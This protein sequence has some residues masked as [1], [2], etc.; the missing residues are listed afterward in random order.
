MAMHRILISDKMSP[1]GLSYFTGREGFEIIYNPEIT[2]EEL[3]AQIGDYDALVIRSRSRVTRAT[4]DRPG[5][6]KIIGRAGAGVDNVDV[7]AATERGVIVMNTPG[8]NTLSTAEHTI[9]MM[10]S[11]ARRIPFADRTMHEGKW[12]KSGIMGVEMFEKTLGI[13]GVGKIGREVATR[14]R[15]FGMDVLVYDPFLTEEAAAQM[16]VTL[17][18]V[19]TIVEKADVLTVHC[20]LN[21]ET[22]GI[23]GAAR[24]AKMKPT[25][26]VVNCARGGIIDEEALFNALKEK[27]IAGASLDVYS[28]E[29]LP[30]DH[31]FR[32]LT[33]VVL[34]P[35][36]AAST[37]E[38]Q[39]KV[40]RDI[41][42]QIFEA[43][44]DGQIRNAV[45]APS[46]D[47]KTYEKMRPVLDLAERLGKFLVQFAKP[48]VKQLDIT[49]SGTATEYS[50]KPITTALV[51]GFLERS[52]SESVNAVNALY[53]AKQ[54]GIKINEI[55]SSHTDDV[56]SGLVTVK[57]TS[58][59]GQVNEISGTLYQSRFPRLVV[60]NGKRVDATPQG[61]MLVLENK[62]VPGIIG[63]I[64]TIL[65][66]QGINIAAMNWGR[67][68]PG[69]DALTV[70]NV[71]QSVSD[72]VLQELTAQN[73]V[74]RAH[75]IVI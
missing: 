40:A 52:V 4:L 36:L 16:G 31:P 42:L 51:K 10:L 71:D 12:E 38:A 3:A 29:P 45:N 60:V 35:H 22:R 53:L 28:Q 5:K 69:G 30:A 65:G 70:I 17:A 6:L 66:K 67:I 20:P 54:L 21:N 1:E 43:L 27:K 37:A 55:R 75:H 24:L 56:F 41:A 9:S 13:V 15:A 68:A 64:G 14:M 73:N 58:D 74:L 39:E 18:D 57:S 34:T 50:T 63:L 59:S 7:E 23:I 32:S 19:D 2:M 8:G 25:A 61:E 44:G 46:L 72:G 33:N 26:L 47:A 49:Y 48:A 62:D 11:L